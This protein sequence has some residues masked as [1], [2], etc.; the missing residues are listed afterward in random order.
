VVAVLGCWITGLVVIL[1]VSYVVGVAIS[2]YEDDPEILVDDA[3]DV[4]LEEV[5]LVFAV[6]AALWMVATIWLVPRVLRG[7]RDAP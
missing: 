6:L 7:D 5:G 3:M 4:A 2:G 1:P